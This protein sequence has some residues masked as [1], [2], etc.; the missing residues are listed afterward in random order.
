MKFW[1][2]FVPNLC[3]SLWLA[4]LTLVILDQYNPMLGFLKG[5]AF[6]LLVLL[7]ALASM[8]SA[9]LLTTD[10]ALADRVRDRSEALP[11]P[12]KG[13]AQARIAALTQEIETIQAALESAR[14]A[15]RQAKQDLDTLNGRA[16]GLRAQL[17]SGEDPD[18]D[19]LL[20]R[21]GELAA[22]QGELTDRRT[23]L[24]ARLAGNTA[25]LAGIR[26]SAGRLEEL[27][28]AIQEGM[29]EAKQ[30]RGYVVDCII[31]EG[32]LVRPMV[33]GG[34]HITEFLVN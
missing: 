5:R 17:E 6:L 1:R 29:A 33:S 11:F 19:A 9:I 22:R 23:A 26:Q 31:Q 32:E 20:V 14:A 8:A 24:A 2:A 34:M 13:E 7:C 27:E 18:E 10:Q 21:Q 3:I 4:L 12:G 15:H 30:G 25:A 28:A 16:A